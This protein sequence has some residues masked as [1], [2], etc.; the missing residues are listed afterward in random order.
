SGRAAIAVAAVDL[1]LESREQSLTLRQ[2]RLDF[3]TPLGFEPVSFFHF[4][5]PAPDF[6]QI[7]LNLL[8]FLK[9]V[10]LTEALEL[11][12]LDKLGFALF[13]DFGVLTCA[14]GA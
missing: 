12:L 14:L 8:S 11:D 2:P 10:I 13:D 7:L 6:L 5:K 1:F 9:G 4:V 3:F